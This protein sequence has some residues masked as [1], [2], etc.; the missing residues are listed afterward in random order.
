MERYNVTGMS[1]AACAARVEK[2]VGSVDG[3]TQCAVNLLTN[4]MTVEGQARPEEIIKAAEDAGYGA[5]MQSR[6]RASAGK[7]TDAAESVDPGTS[8][9]KKRLAASVVFLLILMYFSMGV[10]MLKLPV[11]AFMAGDHVMMCLVQFLLC[12]VIMVI[13]QQSVHGRLFKVRIKT[14]ML[15]VLPL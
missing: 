2:A 12:I 1:C 9:M 13:N 4:S 10:H 6:G 7:G 11:P 3:V 5:A 8:A 15:L 14:A